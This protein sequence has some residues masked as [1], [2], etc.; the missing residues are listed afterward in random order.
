MILAYLMDGHMLFK[1]ALNN[2]KVE[3]VPSVSVHSMN[4]CLVFNKEGIGN[5]S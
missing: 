5:K 2:E 1:L 4:S 3:V